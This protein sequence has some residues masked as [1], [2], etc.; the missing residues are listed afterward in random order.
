MIAA[1]DAGGTNNFSGGRVWAGWGQVS[2][3]PVPAV[4]WLSGS[5]LVAQNKKA[6]FEQA[7]LLFK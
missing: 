2:T 5:G 1:Y 6:R 4:V 3:V 7:F